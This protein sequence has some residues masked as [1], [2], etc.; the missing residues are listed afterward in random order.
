MPRIDKASFETKS[1]Y[2]KCVEAAGV[3][4]ATV[5]KVDQGQFKLLCLFKLTN[6][7]VYNTSSFLDV[8]HP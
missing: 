3:L 7:L 5:Q 8:N 4:G 2:R 6:H 1:T